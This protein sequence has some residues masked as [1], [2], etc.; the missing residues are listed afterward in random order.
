[1]RILLDAMGGD[2]APQAIV[3][4]AVLAAAKAEDQIILVG[5]KTEVYDLIC[6]ECPDGIPQNIT[7]VGASD[8]IT[9]DDAPVKAIKTKT[10]ST[11][12]TAFNILKDGFD[13]GLRRGSR[14]R[15]RIH[16][17]RIRKGICRGGKAE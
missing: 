15:S 8:V 7:I 13:Q 5:P 11:I 16:F 9:N 14:S 12:V 1:M 2:N 17:F 6:E 3:K 10:G 4:G